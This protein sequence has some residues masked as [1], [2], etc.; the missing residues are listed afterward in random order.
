MDKQIEWDISVAKDGNI[1]AAV[2]AGILLLDG[3]VT[4]KDTK[5]G[6]SFLVKASDAGD[7]KAMLTLAM[8]YERGHG[9]PKHLGKAR[10]YYLLGA[11]QGSRRAMHELSRVLYNGALA[12]P[13]PILALAWLKL[14]IKQYFEPSQETYDKLI[15]DFDEKQIEMANQLANLGPVKLANSGWMI[16]HRKLKSNQFNLLSKSPWPHDLFTNQSNRQLG[17]VVENLPKNLR[18]WKKPSFDFNETAAY[19]GQRDAMYKHALNLLF[20]LNGI[21]DLR[22]SIK[23]LE[24]AAARGHAPS[25]SLLGFLTIVGPGV[26]LESAKELSRLEM[27]SDRSDAEAQYLIAKIYQLGLQGKIDH[28][29]ARKFYEL[30]S[31][32]GHILA[33]QD[34]AEM[35]QKGLGGDID[36]LGAWVLL[37][38]LVKQ[39]WPEAKSKLDK[40]ELSMGNARIA[41]AKRLASKPK[42][43]AKTVKKVSKPKPKPVNKALS[44]LKALTIKAEGGA[45]DAQYDL[46]KLYFD[47]TG[48]P[49]N[50][51][52][53]FKWL[54]KAAAQGH[55][56]ACLD[57]S[58]MILKQQGNKLD[59]D[60]ARKWLVKAME[61]GIKQAGDDLFQLD[62]KR[63]QAAYEAFENTKALRIFEQ[64]LKSKPND[65]RLFWA[66]TKT[67]DSL[68]LDLFNAGKKAEAEKVL[69][70][71]MESASAW[72][73]SFPNDAQAYVYLA[74]TTGNLARFKGGKERVQIGS[75]VEGY[76]L[77][78]IET[79][80]SVGRP[81]VI[82]AT[83][84][85]EIS[86]LNWMLKAFAK[87]FLGKLPD[88][89]R[90]DALQLYV[91]GLE[92]DN[93]QIYGHY[94]IAQLYDALGKKDKAQKH[95]KI[96]MGLK[97]KNS[98]DQR[99]LDE[100]KK[101]S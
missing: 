92:K 4:A 41:K 100:L 37:N 84:Y 54:N 73:K 34:L 19:Q 98:G 46:G 96:L 39:N 72:Q 23:L 57:L 78:A 16:P 3:K 68:G 36:D 85:W 10:H 81:Y 24:D 89:T 75:K 8:R 66:V 101:G 52:E 61:K 9:L 59:L 74:V 62:L 90:D 22:K 55:A 6:L 42:T 25:A 49:K 70:E 47:G 28:S 44:P 82:L 40:L 27:L 91:K 56:K 80:S 77:K 63:G 94:K 20:G 53:A 31:A 21:K 1:K 95:R 32:Q 7:W 67:K 15:L 58:K 12:K 2:R 76:C 38:S 60:E 93:N 13:Q 35:Y 71:A 26:E 5:L 45:I 99:I 69:M 64:L 29:K 14:A 43:V 83:Y 86:K 51:T 79:D 87:S 50:Y 30:A 48:A 33:S 88:K 11:K 65:P 17:Y 97:A 18:H